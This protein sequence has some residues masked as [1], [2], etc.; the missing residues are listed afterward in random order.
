M[1]EYQLASAKGE[2]LQPDAGRPRMSLSLI[3][4]TCYL[5][6]DRLRQLDT[7]T[8]AKPSANALPISARSETDGMPEPTS[9]IGIIRDKSMACEPDHARHLADA[10]DS[11]A[12]RVD[13]TDERKDALA[14]DHVSRDC[15][16]S[17]IERQ[18]RGRAIELGRNIRD[19]PPIKCIVSSGGCL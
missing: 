10:Y 6:R 12:S 4:A 16:S 14:V 17:D 1:R 11:S 13:L 5:L 8:T 15:P 2:M 3:R 7:G 18:A 9:Q 19:P